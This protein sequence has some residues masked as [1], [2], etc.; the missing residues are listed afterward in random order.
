MDNGHQRRNNDYSVVRSSM[1]L[2]VSMFLRINKY[3][4]FSSLMSLIHASIMDRVTR[5]EDGNCRLTAA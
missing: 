3:V 2:A 5:K 4:M 1:T